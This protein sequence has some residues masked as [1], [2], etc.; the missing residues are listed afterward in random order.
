MKGSVT[1][2]VFLQKRSYRRRRM[3]DAVRLLPFAGLLLWMLPIFW[4]LEPERGVAVAGST[5]VI[6][7][8]GVWVF[9]IAVSMGLWMFLRTTFDVPERDRASA[10]SNHPVAPED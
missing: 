9:L 4:P 3:M 10:S 5:A 1:A 6:Y 8:F 2:S 7:V